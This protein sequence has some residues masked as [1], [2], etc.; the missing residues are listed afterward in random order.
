MSPVLT[1]EIQAY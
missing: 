1:I